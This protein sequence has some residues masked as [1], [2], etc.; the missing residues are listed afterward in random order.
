MGSNVT[1]WVGQKW[2]KNTLDKVLQFGWTKKSGGN[3]CHIVTVGPRFWGTNVRFLVGRTVRPL[4]DLDLDQLSLG[5]NKQQT[6][7]H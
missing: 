2:T 7:C 3:N 6:N 4:W 1:V 5:P